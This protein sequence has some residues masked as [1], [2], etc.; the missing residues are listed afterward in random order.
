MQLG[1]GTGFSL[2]EVMTAMAAGLI[3][4]A[5]ALQ[6]LLFFQREFVRQHERIMQQQ[7]VRLGLDLLQQELRMAAPES[8]SI[9]SPDTVEFLANVSG[10]MTNIT[11]PAGAGETTVTVQDG[12]GW[13]EHKL[14]GVCWSDVCLRFTLAR[15]GQRNLLT[16]VEAVAQPIP[17]GALV[18]V[19]NRVRYYSRQDE[20]GALRWLRQID[21]GA[22]VVA[23][24]IAAF[25]LR[26]LDAQGHPTT[27]PLSVRLMLVEI[28]LTGRT[29]KEKREISLG[30]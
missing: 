15:A 18:M 2:I 12:R 1:S 30:V 5:A 8:L 23:R 16:F 13:P 29:V 25:T 9:V 7:D 10:L 21:G 6:A 22:S 3:V 17:S 14:V 26:Y 4:L 11:L 27:H 28:A 19:I 24:N 20:H